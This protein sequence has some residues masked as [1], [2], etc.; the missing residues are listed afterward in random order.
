[1]VDVRGPGDHSVDEGQD[2]AARC[3]TTNAALEADGLVAQ[4][5]ETEPAHQGSDEQQAGIGDKI[6]I[7]EGHGDPVDSARYW[8]HRKCLLGVGET[9]TSSTVIFPR[10][11]AFSADARSV[12][13]L[14]KRC[15]EA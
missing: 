3:E 15:I 14:S 1:V 7:I 2:L 11:E 12:N 4:L 9:T 10:R 5:L 6:R 8:L 13:Q